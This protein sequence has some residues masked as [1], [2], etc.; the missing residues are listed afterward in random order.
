MVSHKDSAAIFNQLMNGKIINRNILNNAS[1]REPN[2]LFTEIMDNL[3]DYRNQYEMC[4]FIFVE[5]P[6]YVYII[7][8]SAKDDMKSEIAMRAYTL[9]L[10]I[11]KFL[12]ANGISL[13]KLTDASSGLTRADIER[14]AEMPFT[15]EVL[16]RIGVKSDLMTAIKNT[17]V[18]R[19]IMLEKTSETAFL[20]SESGL[21]F[22]K[23]V[24][25]NFQSVELP[26]AV[27]A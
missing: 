8:Q 18:E 20:L 22:Y 24:V 7:D 1:E 6:D 25:D 13:T 19:Y 10:L 21:A 27:N 9:L 3:A 23:E 14:I 16:L 2:R 15:D 12:T 17:L 26:T 11:G 5:H 4:G